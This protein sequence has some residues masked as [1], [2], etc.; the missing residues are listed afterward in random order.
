MLIESIALDLSRVHDLAR[1]IS[2][3]E[4]TKQVITKRNA[5]ELRELTGFRK[6]SKVKSKRCQICAQRDYVIGK[7]L[8]CTLMV[9]RVGPG[10][11]CKF[12]MED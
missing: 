4:G 2:T 9:L 7:D 1:E 3:F 11:V 6:E 12:F 8:F 10:S 5:G